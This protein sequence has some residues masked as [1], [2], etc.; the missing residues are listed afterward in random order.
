MTP[1]PGD[2]PHDK[3]I[4]RMLRVDHAG[5]YGALRIYAGQLAVLKNHESAVHIRHMAEQERAHLDAFEKLLPKRG[6]R[7]T[8]LMPVWHIG[9][10]LMGA[11]SALLGPKAAMACTAAVESVIDE[12]YARQSAE[13]DEKESEL[14]ATIDAFRAD[15]AAHRDLSLE[16][17]AEDSP[18]YTPLTSVVKLQTKLAIWLS[19]RV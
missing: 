17:G 16:E 13:L 14:K 18:F 7:P 2:L 10:W 11:G 3:R 6:A 9:G 12:H 1:L 15:E 8:A 5:E 4:D 19:E